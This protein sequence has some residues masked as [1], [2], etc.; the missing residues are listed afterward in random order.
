MCGDR[1]TI[2]RAGAANRT[3]VPVA[4]MTTTSARTAAERHEN[5]ASSSQKRTPGARPRHSATNIVR[6]S[7]AAAQVTRSGSA[8]VLAASRLLPESAPPSINSIMPRLS[9][10]DAA[11]PH[12]KSTPQ[13]VAAG[14]VTKIS[15]CP[16]PH[17][18]CVNGIL[19][20]RSHFPSLSLPS[21]MFFAVPPAPTFPNMRA[22]RLSSSPRPA[23]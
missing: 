18:G 4:S 10:G 20:V 12:G 5:P 8:A 15:T 1:L 17:D 2:L 16:K 22:H 14:D 13:I 21:R 11:N 6:G 19:R 9:P 23:A 3:V 7:L